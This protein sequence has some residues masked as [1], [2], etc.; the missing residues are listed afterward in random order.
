MT[1]NDL[2]KIRQHFEQLAQHVKEDVMYMMRQ[3]YDGAIAQGFTES[4]A[5]GFVDSYWANFI[6]I[7]LLKQKYKIGE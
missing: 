4:Q 7:I 5:Q 6:Y 3:I 2:Q 1:D